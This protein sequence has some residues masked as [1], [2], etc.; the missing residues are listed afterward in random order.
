M[1]K[2]LCWYSKHWIISYILLVVIITYAASLAGLSEQVSSYGGLFY[3]VS[4]LCLV[5]GIRY[6]IEDKCLK[7]ERDAFQRKT[8]ILNAKLG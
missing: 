1:E 4:H 6:F 3:L 2:F 5:L 8:N 7:I